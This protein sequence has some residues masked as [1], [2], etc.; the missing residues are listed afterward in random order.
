[1]RANR[2]FESEVL[3]LATT[4]AMARARL[5]QVGFFQSFR[6]PPIRATELLADQIKTKITIRGVFAYGFGSRPVESAKKDGR[7]IERVQR[8]R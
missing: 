3:N 4:C 8:G 7:D 1:L 6:A 2:N 5:P